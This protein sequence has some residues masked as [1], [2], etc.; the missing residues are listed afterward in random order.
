MKKVLIVT[1]Y[2]PPSGG[3]GVQRTLKYVKYLSLFGWQPVVLT[4]KHGEYEA[5]DESLINEIPKETAIYKTNAIEPHRFYKKIIGMQQDDNVP[6][7]AIMEKDVSWKKQLSFWFRINVFI[8]DARVGWIQFAVKA[9]KKIIE[10]ENIALIYSSSPPASAQIIAKKL[11]KWSGLPWVADFRDPWT[12][13]YEHWNCKRTYFTRKIDGFLEKSVL[14]AATAVTS[15]SRLD[16]KN[17]YVKKAPPLEKYFYIPNGYDED[18]F[19][20]NSTAQIKNVKT[21]KIT[22]LHIGSMDEE[23]MPLNVFKA[24]EKLASENHINTENFAIKFIGDFERNMIEKYVNTNTRDYIS[25]QS[26]VP[27]GEIFNYLSNATVL[28]LLTY[29]YSN[30]IPGKTFEYLRS[31]RPLLVLGKEDGEVAEMIKVSG[32]GETIDYYNYE[33]IY[34]YFKLLVTHHVQ[35]NKPVPGINNIAKYERKNLTKQLVEIFD[36]LN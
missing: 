30:N 22:I 2:W 10:D 8:P 26:Y 20:E 12:N 35:N 5:I 16:I 34:N 32:R 7:G 28:L 19:G 25:Y 24:V 3:P 14:S 21:D 33:K 27:H 13:L 4:V 9:G 6:F 18:D 36:S 1:Y 29:K 23:R 31:G 17:N 11:S 15:V